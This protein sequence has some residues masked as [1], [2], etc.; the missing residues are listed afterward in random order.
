MKKKDAAG[1]STSTGGGNNHHRQGQDTAPG[2]TAKVSDAFMI[3]KSAWLKEINADRRLTPLCFGVAYFVSDVSS[4]RTE[5]HSWASINAIAKGTGA[6]KRAV[7]SAIAQLADKH[8][9]RVQ[10]RR[11]QR[12]PSLLW[13]EFMRDMTAPSWKRTS[14]ETADVTSLVCADEP[15][16]EQAQATPGDN[17]QHRQF[18]AGTSAEIADESSY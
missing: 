15:A 9:L 11:T 14:A 10:S 18:S 4:V 6:S 1:A 8:Y 17:G 7:Q 2:V 5:G 13:M 3:A 16:D 12:K